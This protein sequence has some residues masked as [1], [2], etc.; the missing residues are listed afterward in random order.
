MH[1]PGSFSSTNSLQDSL[2]SP[3]PSPS[4]SD[5]AAVASSRGSTVSSLVLRRPA[6][7]VL[8]A[9][10]ELNQFES[11]SVVIGRG[12]GA[13]CYIFVQ[14]HPSFLSRAHARA[15]F[16]NGQWLI[17]DLLSVNGTCINLSKLSPFDE[18]A[19]KPGDHVYFVRFCVSYFF[20]PPPPSTHTHTNNL[21]TH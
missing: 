1:S 6:I 18:V 2:R 19:L 21:H 4:L 3:S 15:F 13:Q 12:S 7:G 17:R 8:P 9:K 11:D 20:P 10:I 5:S 16:K 14:E